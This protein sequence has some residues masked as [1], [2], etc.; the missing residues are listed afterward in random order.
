LETGAIE[1][2]NMRKIWSKFV[3]WTTVVI[4]IVKGLGHPQEIVSAFSSIDEFI[5]SLF[6]LIL[7]GV[8]TSTFIFGLWYVFA[9]RKQKH[10]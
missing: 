8:I 4:A 9:G 7:F 1:E 3:L 5:A 2:I 10:K 6:G